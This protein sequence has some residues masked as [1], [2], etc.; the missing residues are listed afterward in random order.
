MPGL[1]RAQ[2]I[3]D[4]L[5]LQAVEIFSNKLDN[6]AGY[7]V[8]Q[9]DSSQITRY[10]TQNLSELISASTPIFVKSY[11]QGSLATS[12]IRG[13]SAT[14]TQVMWNG[15]NINSP[16][17]GQADFSQVPVFFIDKAT[18]YYGPGSIFETSGGLGGSINLETKTNWRNTLQAEV[19]QQFA[20]FETINT[21]ARIDVG[22]TKFQSSTRLFYTQSANNYEFY[23]IAVSRENPP[24]IE[25]Q[26]AAYKQT[27]LLQELAWNAGAKTLLWAKIWVQENY[28][29][30]P[31]N[32]LVNAPDGNEDSREQ[33][34]RGIIGMDYFYKNASLKIQTG[35]L[36]SFMNYKNEISQ[37]ND[38]NTV[39][40][41]VTSASYNFHGIANLVIT[42]GLA[43]NHHRAKSDNYSGLKYRNEAAIYAGANYSIINRTFLNLLIRQELI[44]GEPAPFTPSFGLSFKP[45]L[46]WG[47][48]L[49]AN[50]ARNFKAPSLNDLYWS[51]GGNPDLLNETGFSYEAGLAYGQQLSKVNLDAQLTWFHNNIDNWILWQPDSVFSYWTPS[52]LKHVLTQGV[53]LSINANGDIGKLTWR[54]SL[55]YAY[56]SAVNEDAVHDNDLSVGKQLIYVP[57]NSLNQVVGIDMLGFGVNYTINY[58]GERFT[59]SDNSRYLPAFTTQDFSMSKSMVIKKNTFNL[60]FAI[61]NFTDT[62]YQLIAWQPM[63]GRN[64]SFSVKYVFTK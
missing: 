40:S 44:D 2:M 55:Q 27:G 10:E 11:G 24:L 59:T 19:I 48:L 58:T 50:I 17:P 51:P 42:T 26:N 56:T 20:S 35:L 37:I 14:H 53:E 23:D 4:T 31:P 38:D 21:S 6:A 33:V 36:Y 3:F 9:I 25:R 5:N 30:I 52:N 1:S 32:M 64:Y 54:Y 41:S 62:Q 46:D 61:N 15:V 12:S 7:K 16:M 60:R 39:T 47:L 28:R 18:V 45:V 43:Y 57:K 34:A 22:N 29:E 63:P 13:A 8:F 49:K